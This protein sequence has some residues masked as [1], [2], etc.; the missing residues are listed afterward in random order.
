[1]TI[2]QLRQTKAVIFPPKHI[3]TESPCHHLLSLGQILTPCTSVGILIVL[4]SIRKF[5]KFTTSFPRCE[6]T[7]SLSISYW[8]LAVHL[9]PI[10]TEGIFRAI[11][12]KTR[13]HPPHT[14]G[15]KRLQESTC[16]EK[17]IRIL[18]QSITNLQVGNDL[19]S[20][21]NEL[22]KK[23]YFTFIHKE[24]QVSSNS[25]SLHFYPRKTIRIICIRIK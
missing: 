17:V 24:D 22:C 20:A 11:L 18:P 4:N 15:K 3:E 19:S 2:H 5:K 9:A 13:A 1:M 25:M 23:E 16:A 10:M 12:H 8:A 7:L 14:L 6:Y 21:T